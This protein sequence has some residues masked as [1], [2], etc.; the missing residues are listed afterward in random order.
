MGNDIVWL[1]FR[2]TLFT[3]VWRRDSERKGWEQ[4]IEDKRMIT[5]IQVREDGG[6][7]AVKVVRSN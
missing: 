5:V 1:I 7:V 6:L 4:R 3:L 2:I